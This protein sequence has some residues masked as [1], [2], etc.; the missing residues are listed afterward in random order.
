MCGPQG[1]SDEHMDQLTCENKRRRGCCLSE[2]NIQSRRRERTYLALVRESACSLFLWSGVSLFS[3]SGGSGGLL[4]P[5]W[6]M[7]FKWYQ[8]GTS[9]NFEISK[10]YFSMIKIILQY[11]VSEGKWYGESFV[12]APGLSKWVF[13]WVFHD[14]LTP[15]WKFS[16]TKCIFCLMKFEKCINLHENL[17]LGVTFY[18]LSEF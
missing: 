5:I 1:V 9:Q 8:K 18:A 16:K 3:R 11:D 15:F 2:F 13:R 14:L 4:S 12:D 10:R 6:A 7:L 17:N